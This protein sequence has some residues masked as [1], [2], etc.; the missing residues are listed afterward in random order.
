MKENQAGSNAVA[1][2]VPGLAS[3][4]L[5]QGARQLPIDWKRRY[6]CRP[7]LLETFVEAQ[8]FRGTCYRPANWIHGGQTSGRGRMDREHKTHGQAVKDIYLYP[9]ARNTRQRRLCVAA[10][11]NPRAIGHWH[12]NTK[13][14]MDGTGC[15]LLFVAR[16]CTEPER[17]FAANVGQDSTK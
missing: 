6:G 8:R 5:A 11:S 3:K 16:E 4:I 7:W 10:R 17:V 12:G 1:C 15:L 2:T 13:F 9:L 14:V